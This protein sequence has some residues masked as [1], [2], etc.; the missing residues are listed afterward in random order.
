MYSALGYYSLR[1]GASGAEAA[2]DPAL[3][4]SSAERDASTVLIDSLLHRPQ[5]GADVQLTLDLECAG[6]D[7]RRRWT[8]S[9]ARSS[10]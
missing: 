9:A 2:F 1:Y 8:V 10:S 3:S 6:T 7:R 5:V 4:G